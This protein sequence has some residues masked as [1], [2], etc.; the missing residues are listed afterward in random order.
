VVAGGAHAG[1]RECLQQGEQ[2]IN[3]TSE[4]KTQDRAWIKS[5]FLVI[6]SETML[7]V[8]PREEC[9]AFQ[10]FHLGPA[11]Y[12]LYWKGTG[13]EPPGRRVLKSEL[14]DITTPVT[15][16]TDLDPES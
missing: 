3:T 1:L 15:S 16:P 9:A 12:V 4:A 8:E 10:L 7:P 11:L 13:E 5:R 2:K 14:H 6:V